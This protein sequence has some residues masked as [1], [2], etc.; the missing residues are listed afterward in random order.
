LKRVRYGGPHR[1]GISGDMVRRRMCQLEKPVVPGE[2]SS[3]RR[4][5]L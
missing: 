2:E 3:S 1:R 4:R 5:R